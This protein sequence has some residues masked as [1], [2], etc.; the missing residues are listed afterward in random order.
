MS[1]VRYGGLGSATAI[2]TSPRNTIAQRHIWPSVCAR[3]TE[4]I[5]A[6]PTHANN[7]N[8]SGRALERIGTFARI[9]PGSGMLARP[10]TCSVGPSEKTTGTRTNAS[11][12]HVQRDR[13]PNQ[14]KAPMTTRIAGPTYAV[15][16]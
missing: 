9:A 15:S 7:G 13:R 10:A 12:I 14:A 1:G 5:T 16:S 8:L 4:T 11:T 2:V 6:M 3:K